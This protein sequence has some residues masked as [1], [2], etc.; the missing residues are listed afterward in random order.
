MPACAVLSAVDSPVCPLAVAS[1]VWIAVTALLESADDVMAP[2]ARF[3]ASPGCER[4]GTVALG[5]VVI[6][7]TSETRS[8]PFW[9]AFAALVPPCWLTY[10][11][12]LSF[13]LGLTNEPVLRL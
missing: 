3:M 4:L 10:T 8:S 12:Y 2:A 5:L 9:S 7:S 6:V 1:P 11:L 13:A